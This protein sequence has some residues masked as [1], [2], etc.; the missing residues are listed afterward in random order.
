MP[1]LTVFRLPDNLVVKP[2][3]LFLVT[4]QAADAGM[5]EPHSI[6]SVSVQVDGGPLIAA[7]LT[8]ISDKKATRAA[9]EVSAQAAPFD[10]AGSFPVD[11]PLPLDVKSKVFPLLIRPGWT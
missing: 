2:N 4:G 1:V 8:Q 11:F 6:D 3:Q 9:F 5:P 10:Q 7:T